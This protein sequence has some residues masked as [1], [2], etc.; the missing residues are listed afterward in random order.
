MI[1]LAVFGAYVD[2]LCPLTL[3][4][5]FMMDLL[6][7]RLGAVR[8]DLSAYRQAEAKGDRASIQSFANRS[9]IWMKTA[10]FDGAVMGAD[11]L[12]QSEGLG[13]DDLDSNY[14]ITSKI[15][16]L[17]SDGEDTGSTI[18]L[19]EAVSVAQEFGVKIYSI[20]IHGQPTQRDIAGLFM[21]RQTK[22]FDDSALK[23]LASE[24]GGKFFEATNPQALAAV[25]T[26]IDRLEKTKISREI[27]TDYAPWHQ[28]WLLAGF[29]CWFIFLVLQHT[30]YRELP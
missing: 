4:H 28:P 29:F 13:D 8:K 1:S 11:L 5:S 30:I 14:K 25:M 20:A 16:I 9:P 15:M 6:N 12:H 3:D 17:L 19:D 2:D 24:T 7:N 18:S 22:P 26:E 23:T 27:S 21:S 10:I